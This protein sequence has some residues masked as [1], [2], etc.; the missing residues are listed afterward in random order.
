MS[1]CGRGQDGD[2]CAGGRVEEEVVAGGDDHEEHE[3]A[4]QPPARPFGKTGDS[5]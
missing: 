5:G 4:E 2:E 1:A 3:A